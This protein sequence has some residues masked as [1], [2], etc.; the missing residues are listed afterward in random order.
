MQAPQFTNGLF[1]DDTLLNGMASVFTQSFKDVGDGLFSEGLISPASLAFSYSNLVVDVTA[2]LPFRV[3]FGDGVL[4]AGYGNTDGTTSD[5]YSVNFAPL[6]PS[7][8]SVTAYLVA[9]A[10]QIQQTPLTVIG[11][12]KGHPDYNPA[13]APFQFYSVVQ[14]TLTLS[15]TTTAPDNSTMFEIGRTTL[16]AGQ[17]SITSLD[18]TNQVQARPLQI[19]ESHNGNPNGHVAGTKGSALAQPS[20]VWDYAENLLWICTTTGDSANAVWRGQA[21]LDS[22][23]FSG[24]PTVPTPTAGDNSTKIASTAFTTAAVAA[25]TS[26]AEYVEATKA[27][28][29]SP[30]FTGSPTAPTPAGNDNSGKIPNTY[31]FHNGGLIYI[32]NALGFGFDANGGSGYIKLPNWLGSFIIQWGATNLTSFPQN[33]NFPIAFPN[34]CFRVLCNEAHA[35]G[36]WAAHDPTLYGINAQFTSY[37]SAYGLSWNG[38]GWNSGNDISMGWLAVGY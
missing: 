3:L 4:A 8:G 16:S 11:P 25:E 15:A 21:P 38:S 12:P 35:G 32:A 6:V 5:A 14:D 20:M 34:S 23:A 10:T 24:T 30:A 29:A 37:F 28:L 19:V 7:S 36:T 1:I 33:I 26:R 22:P 18:T 9:T 27:P 2:P 17:T 13:N 31:W